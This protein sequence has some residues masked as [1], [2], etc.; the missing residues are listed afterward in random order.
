MAD[1]TPASLAAVQAAGAESLELPI[2]TLSSQQADRPQGERTPNASQPR[3]ALPILQS[4]SAS[5]SA[6]ASCSQPLYSPMSCGGTPIGSPVAAR[7]VY[8]TTGQQLVFSPGYPSAVGSP[9]VMRASPVPSPS[10]VVPPVPGSPVVR[11][12]AGGPV[13]SRLG[14]QGFSPG[15][16][17]P[18]PR[19]PSVSLTAL[20]PGG[21]IRHN[22]AILGIPLDLRGGPNVA[23]PIPVRTS[24]GMVVAPSPVVARSGHMEA[25]LGLQPQQLNFGLPPALP[26]SSAGASMQPAAPR[27]AIRAIVTPLRS[28]VRGGA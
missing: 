22:A 7:Y 3:A 13:L 25:P 28:G 2:G 4:P 11:R 26:G 16:Q 19:S 6:S 5:S 14:S 18:G 8:A 12:Q 1:E 27:A 21:A 15:P 17:S 20:S 9:K 10:R 23:V 24:S